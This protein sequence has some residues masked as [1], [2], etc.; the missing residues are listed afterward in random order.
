MT[1]EALK[2]FYS[3]S[4]KDEGLRN[5]LGN[6]LKIL[7]HQNLIASWHDR[8][9]LPGDEWDH[10]I[11]VNQDTADIILL[12]ISSDF[13]ASKYCWD[14]EIRKAMELHESGQACVV[15]VILRRADWT[16][17]PFSKLQAVPRNAQPVMSFSDRDEAFEFVTQQ[18]RQLAT[19]L[20]ERCRK[21]REQQQKD[22][23][24]AT[25]RQ[26]FEAFAADGE[27]SMGEQFLLDDLQQQLGLIDADVQAITQD[28]LDPVADPQQLER[29]RQFFVKAIAQHGYPLNDK[30]RADLKLVQTH[31]KL[32]DTDIAQVEAP[33]IAQQ[34][35]AQQKQQ[36]QVEALK[37]Q[38]S[39]KQQGTAELKQEPI[40]Q[41]VATD[42]IPLESEKGVDYTQ[43]R[44][45]L[46]AGKWREADQETA[47]RMLEAM[48]REDWWNV[49]SQDLL[50]FLCKDLKTID[51]LWVKYSKG[52]FGFS[53]QKQIY[54]ECGAKLDGK[55]PGDK[56][57]YKFCDRVGWSRNGKYVG[58]PDLKFNPLLSPKGELPRGAQLKVL[59]WKGLLSHRDL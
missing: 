1:A 35:A 31:L 52:H 38:R 49:G 15:P 17:A 39:L 30:V 27:I 22:E 18:I 26:Q 29:Y 48:G 24:I 56:I 37:Q 4:H 33:I 44:D 40:A 51:R 58:Y 25:Y 5:E 59:G 32:S 13:I 10:E 50:N 9:I 55:Y 36:R 20:I 28:I 57:W 47:D 23:A 46:K 16:N 42:D 8:K 3:Y 21:L 7:E 2:L 14:I 53:V 45:F 6:H 19:G 54:V 34:E 41:T 12:L 11:T 43:L